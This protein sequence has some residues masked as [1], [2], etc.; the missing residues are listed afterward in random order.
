LAGANAI[1]LV[2]LLI[3]ALGALLKRL[4]VLREEDGQ[5]VARVALNVTLPAVVLDTVPSIALEASLAVLPLICLVHS[6][7]VLALSF[8][9]FRRQEDRTKAVLL[10]T[11]TGYNVA[12]FAFP[13]VEALWGAAGLQR[14]AMFD[15]GNAIVLLGVN[16]LIASWYGTRSTG[17]VPRL[18]LRFVGLNLLKSVPLGSLAVALAL[19]LLGLRLPPLLGSFVGILAKA[20]TP[21]VLLLLGLYLDLRPDGGQLKRTAAILALRYGSGAVTGLACWFLLPLAAEYRTTLLVG[22]L[23][24][25]G[26]S[27]SAFAATFGLDRKLASIVTNVTLLASFGLLWLI[28]TAL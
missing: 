22:L 14:L 7:L 26:T 23:L 2:S 10:M 17:G 28:A 27:V 13:I 8:R 16:Y 1:F 24:P 9:L 4:G 6:G 21:V 5:A 12:L 15:A 18:T 20:N 3:I 19:N 11:S 25:V